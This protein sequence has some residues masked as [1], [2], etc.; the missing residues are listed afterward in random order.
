MV[1]LNILYMEM[2]NKNCASFYFEQERMRKQRDL[3]RSLF[4]LLGYKCDREIEFESGNMGYNV[5]KWIKWGKL[6]GKVEFAYIKGV[7]METN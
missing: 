6:K 5:E 3:N 7:T 4:Y 1:R 2:I